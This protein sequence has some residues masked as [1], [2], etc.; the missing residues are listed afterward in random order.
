M[1]VQVKWSFKCK[2]SLNKSML[3]GAAF[4]CQ[5]HTHPAIQI[6]HKM[7]KKQCIVTLIVS[8][9]KGQ[10]S[11]QFGY[12]EC[13]ENGFF[14]A[15]SIPNISIQHQENHSES[16]N[17]LTKGNTGKLSLTNSK[18]ETCQCNTN[19]TTQGHYM[20]EKVFVQDT[21]TGQYIRKGLYEQG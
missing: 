7:V 18:L 1:P 10:L 5:Y 16:A 19:A 11:A 15:I 17:S 8:R 3:L 12:L 21:H 2:L 14:K 13:M 6:Y 20:R 9:F 4:F